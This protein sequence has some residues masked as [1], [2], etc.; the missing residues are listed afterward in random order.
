MIGLGVV[1]DENVR[2][3]VAVE[4]GTDDSQARARQLAETRFQ[5]DI[6][7]ANR[8]WQRTGRAAEIAI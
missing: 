6:F 7:K 4:I 2:P 8:F 1:G 3:A 5:R